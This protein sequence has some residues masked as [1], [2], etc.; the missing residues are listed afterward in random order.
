MKILLIGPQGCGKGTIGSMLSDYLD[1]PLI[2]AGH[3]LR[4]V[5]EAHP[6]KREIQDYMARGELVPQD[7]VA[8]LLREETSKDSCKNGFIFDGWGR[9]MKDLHFYD[10][11]FDKV[12]LI[13]ISP[14]TSVKRISSRRTCDDCGAVF[15]IVSVPPKIEGICDE[16]GGRLIQREDDT[17]EAVR[18]RLEIFNTET[19]EV[20]EH[21]RNEGKLVEIDGEG[22]PEEVF[23]LALEALK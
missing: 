23:N 12:I 4:E 1:I 21:F 9:T 13:N 2:S 8:D 22:R 7:L 3:I 11:D 20:I 16:C 14:E 10:P 17:E 18:R 6:R 5:G 19:S 15:N